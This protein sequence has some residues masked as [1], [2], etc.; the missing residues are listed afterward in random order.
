[1]CNMPFFVNR[2]TWSHIVWFKC[3]HVYS[4][5]NNK[6]DSLLESATTCTIPGACLATKNSS[7][8]LAKWQLSA[9]F[10]L[11]VS[12]LL[13]PLLTSKVSL[14]EKNV[15]IFHQS[16]GQTR[17]HWVLVKKL[18]YT[19][20]IFRLNS[21]TWLIVPNRSVRMWSWVKW[22]FASLD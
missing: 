14:K 11:T 15:A 16:P 22:L 8:P 20:L 18:C 7:C 2:K 17:W 6:V 10:K 3:I 12:F 5:E 13:N 21:G 9:I 19:F 4:W 1:M